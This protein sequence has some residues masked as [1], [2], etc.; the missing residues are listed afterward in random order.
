MKSITAVIATLFFSFMFLPETVY[1]ACTLTTAPGATNFSFGTVTVQRDAPIGSILATKSLV[2][3][4]ARFNCTSAWNFAGVLNTFTTPNPYGNSVYDTNIS[5]VGLQISVGGNINGP[6]P[7]FYLKNAGGYI[8]QATMVANLVKTSS[9][10]VG[11]GNLSIGVLATLSAD[12]ITTYSLGLTGANT[13]V[14]VACSVTNTA[15]NVPMGNVQRSKFSGPG[16]E[17][18]PVPFSIPLDC[19]ANT[20]VNFKLDATADSSGAPGVMA[21][22]SSALGTAAS[23]VGIKLTRSGAPLAFGTVIPAGTVTS[24]GRFS[25]PLVARYYQTAPNVTAGQANAT[26]TF[27]MTYN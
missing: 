6:L 10:A 19:D 7:Y 22:N 5:G 15:I 20:R 27:T 14:S 8:I 24:A 11:S 13:I 12:N 9:G 2:A 26:A 17:G 21:L 25:I 18:D 4:G 3:M 16:Y 23:G 1:A